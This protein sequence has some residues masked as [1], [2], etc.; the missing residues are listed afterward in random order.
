MVQMHGDRHRGMLRRGE[1]HGAYQIQ[2]TVGQAYF[3]NLQN[4]RRSALFCRPD[5]AL[6]AFHIRHREGTEGIAARLRIPQQITHIN[7]HTA[8]HL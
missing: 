1:H 5:N 8:P 7:D 2:R 6:Y 3:R 4:Y